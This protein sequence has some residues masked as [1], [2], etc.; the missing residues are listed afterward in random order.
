MSD[1]QATD[2]ARDGLDACID[3]MGEA[4]AAAME[5]CVT[6]SDRARLHQ[7][8][9]SLQ[10]RTALRD[11]REPQGDLLERAVR[12]LASTQGRDCPGIALPGYPALQ[13]A[14]GGMRGVT[15]LTGPTGAGKTTLTLGLALA[16]AGGRPLSDADGNPL[17]PS[18]RMY[19]RTG[20]IPDA[21]RAAVVYVT[22]EMEPERLVVSM[23][24]MLT[25]MYGVKM[26]MR[27]DDGPQG[28]DG[29]R[30]TQEMREPFEA[31]RGEL[32]DMLGKSLHIITPESINM[33][34]DDAPGQHALQGLE[35]AVSALTGGMR[36]LVV[37]DSIA[38][39]DSQV[40][41]ARGIDGRQGVHRSDL[42]ADADIAHGLRMWRRSL[43]ESGS[44]LLAVHEEGKGRTGTGDV[45]AA[46]GSSRYAYS[47]DAMLGMMYADH[48]GA[49][50]RGSMTLGAR[51]G[52]LDDGATQVD[53]LVTK[54][55][56][57]GM[58]GST[59]MMTHHWGE[60]RIVEDGSEALLTAA[61]RR[62]LAQGTATS[63]GRRG[64]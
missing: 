41:P 62:E 20:V 59:V 2:A 43:R 34:W 28:D 52:M 19:L 13:N 24:S 37:L 46:R 57:G 23:L 36:T 7:R 6:A 39:L 11:E 49:G 12:E 56:L 15:L 63:G 31:A 25:G 54:A 42:D 3:V 53:V 10:Y 55:R 4:H 18:E 44:A 1:V 35:G 16:V 30:M 26:L 22:C 21:E 33:Q 61:R 60:G 40:M 51:H 58:G 17:T 29:L 32:G 64:K 8:M 38:T 9:L 48:D 5:R 27:G 45:H 50:E 14:L 47:A